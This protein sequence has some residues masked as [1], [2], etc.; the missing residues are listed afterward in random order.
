MVMPHQFILSLFISFFLISLALADDRQDVTQLH[1]FASHALVQS[2]RNQV[3]GAQAGHLG[4]MLTELGINA[5]W[6]V[7][8]NCLF[9]GQLLSRWDGVEQ[10]QV[11]LD[12]A[13]VD[14]HFL[15][16]NGHHV[17]L[18]VGMIKNPYGFYNTTRDVAHTR[19]TILLPQSIYH[20]QGR[21]FFLSA[22]GISLHGREDDERNAFSW[23]INLL[24]PD[25]NNPNMVAFMV[26]L[27]NGQLQAHR[28]FLSQVLWERDGGLWRAG[29]TLG[30]LSM[31]YQPVASDFAGAGRVTGAGNVTLNTGVLS[32]EHNRENWSYTTEYS[33]T[34]QIRNDFNVP[35]APFLDRDTSIEEYYIQTIW[36]FMSAWQAIARYDAIYV[37]TADRNGALFAANTGQPASQRYARDW[38][39]GLRY[40]PAPAWSLFAEFH[41]VNGTAW[42]S[43]ITN[44]A[45]STQARWN[46]LLFQAAYHF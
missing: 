26:G 25:V 37:D 31:H 32:L 44:P 42:L 28:S 43:K 7:N 21:D 36:R 19:P 14:S 4:S 3:G 9:S 10:G 1:G 45:I 23:Q 13:F 18:Q 39:L 30:S 2:D 29:A 24:K 6:Q 40:E 12:Y 16:Q 46:M 11:R 8:P 27:Q 22:P 17:G 20:D 34:R 5:S 33:R 38:T 15:N 35:F 41:R